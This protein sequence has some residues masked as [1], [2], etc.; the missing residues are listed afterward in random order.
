MRS[1]VILLLLFVLIF[2]LNTSG[3]NKFDYLENLIDKAIELNPNIK[4]LQA[5]LEATKTR[6]AQNSNL[7]DPVLSVGATN[8]PVNSFSFTQEPMT[9]KMVSLSQAFP[10]PGKLSTASEVFEQDIEVVRQEIEEEKN[11]LRLKV[12]DAYFQ[13]TFVREKIRLTK[14]TKELLRTIKEVVQTKYEVND[15]SQQ[16][17]FKIELELTKLEENL[18]DLYSQEIIAQSEINILLFRESDYSVET[19][20]LDSFYVYEPFSSDSL[21]Q[22]AKINKPVLSQIELMQDKAVKMEELSEYEFYPDFNLTLQYSQRDEISKTNTDLNDFFSI[23]LGIK[24]PINYGDKKSAKVNEAVA[25]QQLY[26]EQ[27]QGNLQMLRVSIEASLSKLSSL[28]ERENLIENASLIQA[29]E[30][31]NSALASYQVNKVDF[32][33]VT[34]ALNKLL[35]LQIDLYKIRSDYYRE[36]AQVEYLTGSNLLTNSDKF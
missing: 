14:A 21:L 36:I 29:Q 25:L 20:G 31:F 18:S 3:Q 16:N 2:N 15:A 24:L 28:L 9:G 1:N 6:P 5:K 12:A 8:L 4:M 13:L 19:A 7:P 22:K 33:N 17:I 34:D 10:F 11:R 27:Y 30:N 32:I 26:N 23:I 35:N